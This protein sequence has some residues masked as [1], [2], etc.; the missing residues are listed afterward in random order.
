[1]LAGKHTGQELLIVDNGDRGVQP[2]QFLLKLW[3]DQSALVVVVGALKVV[4]ALTEVQLQYGEAVANGDAW[5]TEQEV[6]GIVGVHRIGPLVQVVV[7]YQHGHH[8]RL[9]R[10]RCHLEGGTGQHEGIVLGNGVPA[11]RQQVQQIGARVGV[12]LCYLVQPDGCLYGFALAEEQTQVGPALFVVEPEVEQLLGDARGL[13]IAR[14]SP[15]LHLATDAVDKLGIGVNR[16]K[17]FLREDGLTSSFVWHDIHVVAKRTTPVDDGLIVYVTVHVGVVVILWLLVRIVQ[18]GILVIGCLHK[19]L[20]RLCVAYYKN[21]SL[22][23]QKKRGRLLIHIPGAWSYPSKKQVTSTYNVN[24]RMFNLEILLRPSFGMFYKQ[25]TL[26]FTLK[27]HTATLHSGN[28]PGASVVYDHPRYLL[29]K[30]EIISS[31]FIFSS[32]IFKKR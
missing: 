19:R 15:R 1:M 10:T 18:Y 28:S 20:Y 22:T 6:V 3:G 4:A 7:E 31:F 21:K 16:D 24:V 12:A 5:R 2:A 26:Y 14:L 23:K 30:Y 17:V 29:Q 32:K 25:Q 13:G 27:N 9:A 11:L 8:H